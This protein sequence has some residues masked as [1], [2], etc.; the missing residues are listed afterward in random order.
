MISGE[1]WASNLSP[2]SVPKLR[3]CPHDFFD[4]DDVTYPINAA[5][6]QDARITTNSDDSVRVLPK[7]TC[8]NNENLTGIYFMSSFVHAQY[9]INISIILEIVN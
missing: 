7:N 8:E 4:E 9:I 1:P 5:I 6:I 3:Q 2:C